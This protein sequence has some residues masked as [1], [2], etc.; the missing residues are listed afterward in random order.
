M[1]VGRNMRCALVMAVLLVYATP[2]A[3]QKKNGEIYV[4]PFDYAGGGANLTRA[5]QEGVL[6]ANPALMPWGEKFHRYAGMQTSVLA[7][8]NS[9]GMVK[10][11]ARSKGKGSGAQASKS[12]DAFVDDLFSKPVHVGVMDSIAW[13]T[14]NFGFDVFARIEPDIAGKQ[15]G[16]GGLP[17]IDFSAEAYAG[18]VLGFG[19]RVARFMSLGVTVK[20]LYVSEPHKEIE[21]TDQTEVKTLQKDPSK[22]LAYGKGT[23]VDLGMLMFQKN[24]MCDLR[25]ALKVDDVGD[26]HFTNGQKPFRQTMSSGVGMTFHGATEALHL[27]LDY[28]DILGEYKEEMFKRVYAGAK[29]LMRNHL[30]FAAGYYQ[31]Y[32]TFGV[33]IDLWAMH[34]GFSHYS[35]EL[36]DYMGEK[37]RNIYQL[38]M[39]IGF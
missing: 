33:R 30:G 34:L 28:R 25:W 36:G 17:V 6:F 1:S 9:I 4:E 12:T 37:R 26:T 27:A 8:K 21:L 11:A 5:S 24:D 14:N 29:L 31:G 7:D 16:A 39:G 18:A 15:F 32:P 22:L 35:R 2:G 3:A 19:A 13:I 23:G 10:D 38:Y 20:E